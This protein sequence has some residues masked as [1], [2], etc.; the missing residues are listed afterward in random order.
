LLNE[1]GLSQVTVHL[2]LRNSRN[3]SLRYA[4]STACNC[5]CE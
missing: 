2:R 4:T 3:C 5:T 1:T